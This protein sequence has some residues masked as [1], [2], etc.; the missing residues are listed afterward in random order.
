[1]IARFPQFSKLELADKPEV[2]SITA[3]F[4][5]YSDF[6]FTSLFCWNTDGSTQVSRLGNNLIIQ[7]PDYLTGEAT[8][9]ILGSDDC[10][11]AVATCLQHF[12]QLNMVPEMVVEQLQD[13]QGV[14]IQEQPEQA[15]YIFS[16]A[17]LAGMPGE[18][19]RSK[20]K[21]IHRFERAYEGTYNV[22]ELNLAKHKSSPLIQQIFQDWAKERA[23]QP[24][25]IANES[26]AITTLLTYAEH[27]N[28]DVLV[29]LINSKVVGFSVHEMLPGSYSICHFQKTILDYI[30]ADVFLTNQAYIRLQETGCALVNWEQDLGLPGLHTLKQSYHP[31]KLLRKYQITSS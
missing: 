25:D 31:V 8:Y 30:G 18:T 2:E 22:I 13:M 10:R 15:D 12:R 29:L 3:S 14:T 28:V 9:S 5:P 26:A 17:D 19:Y 24:E 6:N 4:E 23:R 21:S 1:M 16:V 7:L 20:R 27:L 11:A